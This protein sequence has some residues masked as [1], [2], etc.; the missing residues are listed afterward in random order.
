MFQVDKTSPNP[1]TDHIDLVEC[2]STTLPI[3]LKA[4]IF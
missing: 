3:A 4:D 1:L 2:T